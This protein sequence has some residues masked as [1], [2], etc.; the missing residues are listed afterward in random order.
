[1]SSLVQLELDE[2]DKENFQELQQSVGDA[3]R[4][5]AQIA[6]KIRVRGAE[7]KHAALTFAEL[8][9]IPDATRSFEQVGK[10]FLLRPLPELKQKL[11]D[12]CET[13]TKEVT[14]LTD[15]KSHVEEVRLPTARCPPSVCGVRGAY[16]R[17]L[18][19]RL[20]ATGLQEDAGRLP[21]VCEDPHGLDR[22]RRGQEGV[23]PR[24]PARQ[25]ISYRERPCGLRSH[26]PA[27]VGTIRQTSES[28]E[29]CSPRTA[30]A[31]YMCTS[32][33]QYTLVSSVKRVAHRLSHRRGRVARAATTRSHVYLFARPH[34]SPDTYEYEVHVAHN[35]AVLVPAVPVWWVWVVGGRGA[36][37]PRPRSAVP[38]AIVVGGG[39]YSTPVPSIDRL[40]VYC[41]VLA[42][43]YRTV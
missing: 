23:S 13:T 10:M 32:L 16:P 36:G 30:S 42:I 15:K 28:R 35:T 21:G 37:A 6:N 22:R 34:R 26:R 33:Q 17:A 20:C 25:R 40:I 41:T 43:A 14:A 9:P 4:E 29:G 12:L 27:L 3:Q 31:R 24:P 1:M 38:V 19:V 18:R 8:E 11:T 7:G 39:S 5:L 2:K